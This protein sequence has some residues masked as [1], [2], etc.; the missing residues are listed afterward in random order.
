MLWRQKLKNFSLIRVILVDLLSVLLDQM[1][2]YLEYYQAA[3]LMVECN[4]FYLPDGNLNIFHSNIDRYLWKKTTDGKFINKHL[5]QNWKYGNNTFFFL[6]T[7]E[8]NYDVDCSASDGICFLADTLLK[9]M[10]SRVT[11]FK[12]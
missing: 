4:H 8:M 1:S 2:I 5:Q 12:S 11:Y 9:L 10:Q 6:T 7:D 3:Q